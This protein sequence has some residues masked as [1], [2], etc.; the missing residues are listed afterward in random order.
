MKKENILSIFFGILGFLIFLNILVNITRIILFKK[1]LKELDLK[2]KEVYVEKE[3]LK[4]FAFENDTSKI[5]NFFIEYFSN[6]NFELIEINEPTCSKKEFYNEILLNVILKGNYDNL[7]NLINDIRTQEKIIVIEKMV[8]E[9]EEKNL[10]IGMTL[11]TY[12]I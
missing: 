10:K 12:G 3:K 8:L 6:K 4:R 9:A 7:I 1:Q 11:K 2:S 5:K